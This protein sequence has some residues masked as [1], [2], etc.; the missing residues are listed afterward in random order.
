MSLKLMYITNKPEVAKIAQNAGVDSIFVDLEIIGKEE[1][2][3]GLD[4]VISR[5]K[6]ED[7]TTIKESLNKSQLLVRVNPIYENSKMEIDEVINRGADIV[8]LPMFRSKREVEKFIKYVDGRAKVCLLLETKEA[9]ERLKDIL[10]VK[11]I[12]EIHIGLNDLHLAYKKKFM[13]ELLANGMVEKI[14][15]EIKKTNIKYGFGGIAS[16]GKGDIK[17]EMILKEHY[18]LG[19]S[20]VILSRSF[21][22][23]EK[24]NTLEEIEEIFNLEVKKIRQL[25]AEIK[26][27]IEYFNKNKNSINSIVK[28]FIS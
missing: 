22:N 7:V 1:R 18:R 13:F 26:G 3:G 19:S 28:K 27:Y 24:V 14:C 11:G 10:K 21:C 17:A 9:V 23:L 2:Q 6:I 4:T 25:E 15:N 12:D 5:H 20:Q 8:M 16:L